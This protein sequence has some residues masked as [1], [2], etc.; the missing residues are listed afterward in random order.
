M[1]AGL[2]PRR[3]GR[4]IKRPLCRAVA[5]ICPRIQT[6]NGD[7]VGCLV[8]KISLKSGGLYQG[9]A[10]SIFFYHTRLGVSIIPLNTRVL[11]ARKRPGQANREWGKL[12][13]L[14]YM[15]YFSG[16]LFSLSQ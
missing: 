6:A 12:G 14:L 1:Q 5:A 2:I 10:V 11:F 15:L 4:A 16:E 8:V 7:A 3:P 9:I 13:R